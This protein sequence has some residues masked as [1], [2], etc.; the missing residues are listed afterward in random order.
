MA[1]FSLDDQVLR[2]PNLNLELLLL[3]E[4]LIAIKLLSIQDVKDI[5]K[6]KNPAYEVKRIE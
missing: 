4:R 6:M 3:E 2:D 1:E 5:Q